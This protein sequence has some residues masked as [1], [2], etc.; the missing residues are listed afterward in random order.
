LSQPLFPSWA[1]FLHRLVTTANECGLPHDPEELK[2]YIDKG[3][4]YLD[5]A[6]TCV[7]SISTTRY[8]DLMEEVF[9]KNF[10]I[11]QVP[12]GYR[13]LIELS[14][15]AIITTN[16]DRIPD[17]AGRGHYRIGTNKNA[18]EIMR[19]FANGKD[20]VFKMHGDI[21]DQSSII[22]KTSDYQSIF[23]SNDSTKSLL[24]SLLST[25]I[26]IFVGFSLSDPHISIIL[27]SIKSI[28]NDIP[29][30]HYVL[31]NETSSFKISSF[32]TKYGVKVI[33]YT[34]SSASHP[35]VEEFLHSLNHKI[36]T[37]SGVGAESSPPEF[38]NLQDL[39][40][41]LEASLSEI[42][43]EDGFSIYFDK[44]C[45]HITFTPV[46]E[47]KNEVQQEILA[48]IKR[49]N[50]NCSFIDSVFVI[51]YAQNQP[52][53][54]VCENQPALLALKVDFQ[55]VRN[56]SNKLVTTSTFWKAI[57][58][59]AP[60]SISDPFQPEKPTPFPLH[61]GIMEK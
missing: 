22:L 36:S 2:K 48:L 32:E 26:L 21:T 25:K 17:V 53:D 43:L 13:A 57:T 10:S 40:I 35:E 4:N 51:A 14:P 33:P 45:L 39:L 50:F 6:E 60:S 59:F 24:K 3:E 18:P 52:N 47:T 5:I 29:L 31:L 54:D 46:G 15:K 44:K 49:I 12:S 58:F 55:S 19:A 38:N 23:N 61:P 56:F 41:H 30:S 34:P 1:S 16:Y 28:N 27:E 20:I 11:E 9:D 8:R 42:L 37:P 7:N